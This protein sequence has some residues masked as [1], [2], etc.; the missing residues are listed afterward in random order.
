MFLLRSRYHFVSAQTTGTDD[1]KRLLNDQNLIQQSTEKERRGGRSLLTPWSRQLWPPANCLT[2]FLSPKLTHVRPWPETA[3]PWA[4]LTEAQG[5]ARLFELTGATVPGAS[6]KRRAYSSAIEK[7]YFRGEAD[8]VRSWVAPRQ[9][10]AWG[11]AGH[12]SSIV[13]SRSCHTLKCPEMSFPDDVTAVLISFDCHTQNCS[14][15]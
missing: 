11:K 14:T 1:I 8:P 13:I 15:M 12:S 9:P 6:G 4:T 7:F 10:A 3:P 2:T 5:G